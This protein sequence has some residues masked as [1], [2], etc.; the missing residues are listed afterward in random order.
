M[1]FTTNY[2]LVMPGQVTDAGIGEYDGQVIHYRISGDRF[3]ADDHTLVI[4]ATSRTTN[5]WAFIVTFLIVL[6]AIG[7]FFLLKSGKNAGIKK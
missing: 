3:I 5:V 2:D 6:I 4:A 1:A 7:S